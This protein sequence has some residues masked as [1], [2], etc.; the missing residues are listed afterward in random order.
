MISSSSLHEAAGKTGALPSTIKPLSPTPQVFGRAFTVQSPPGDNLWIH[1]AIYAA[2]PGD[3]LV[4]DV[5][6]QTEHGY[7]GEIMAHAA[8]V[9]GIAGLVIN[10]G[11]R[12]SQLL[13]SMN[14]PVFSEG[15]CIQGTSKDPEGFGRL[16]EPIRLGNV[17][18]RTGDLVVGDAD[19]VIVIPDDQ[20]ETV[21][22]KAKKR[23]AEEARIIERLKNGETTIAIY[24]LANLKTTD[25]AQVKNIKAE[26]VRNE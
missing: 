2:S 19:G 8:Q 20:V 17:L 4:V 6:G 1:H 18:I 10:G 23:D 14:F 25:F 26:A 3:V 11:V 12:D 16:G 21:I 9:R 7:F 22:Q 13:I 24:S 15:V 5:S